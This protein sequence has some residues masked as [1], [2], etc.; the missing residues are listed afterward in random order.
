MTERQEITGIQPEEQHQA[1]LP[2]EGVIMQAPVVA[3]H[4]PHLDASATAM[5][6]ILE[7]IHNNPTLIESALKS[8]ALTTKSK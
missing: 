8:G 5:G 1:K 7:A 6:Q 3:E 4:T 2:T